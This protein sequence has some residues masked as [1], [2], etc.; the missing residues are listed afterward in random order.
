MIANIASRRRR[1]VQPDWTARL[2]VWIGTDGAKKVRNSTLCRVRKL[3]TQ[4]QRVNERT[5]AGSSKPEKKFAQPDLFCARA[6]LTCFHFTVQ[7]NEESPV[8]RALRFC[9]TFIWSDFFRSRRLTKSLVWFWL[10]LL[11]LLSVLLLLL[12]SLS[13]PVVGV[14]RISVISASI[15]RDRDWLWF[16]FRTH[17]RRFD[18]AAHEFNLLYFWRPHLFCLTIRVRVEFSYDRSEISLPNRCTS[19]REVGGIG[20]AR[21][22]STRLSTLLLSHHYDSE[23]LD[24]GEDDVI[25][26]MCNLNL[27]R[28]MEVSSKDPME[29]RRV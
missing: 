3:L 8:E 20:I 21:D 23:T 13:L 17:Q 4:S 7:A 26:S 6:R 11:L 14:R 28:P 29:K 2:A 9:N 12:L 16:Y 5:N 24:L 25:V 18:Q 22:S 15:G 19:I 27:R 1:I 10:L